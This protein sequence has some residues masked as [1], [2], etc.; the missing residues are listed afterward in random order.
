MRRQEAIGSKQ[1]ERSH[2]KHTY[3]ELLRSFLSRVIDQLDGNIFDVIDT[4]VEVDRVEK[5][6]P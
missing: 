5:C 1:I 6:L 4:D 3:Q 2:N